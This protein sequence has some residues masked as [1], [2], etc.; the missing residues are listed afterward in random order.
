[1]P[2]IR[3]GTSRGAHVRAVAEALMAIIDHMPEFPSERRVRLRNTLSALRRAH[4]ELRQEIDLEHD[5]QEEDG[6][7]QDDSP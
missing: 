2:I 1:M 6:I 3:G 4:P 5:L 7:P